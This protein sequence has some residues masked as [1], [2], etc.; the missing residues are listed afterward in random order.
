MAEL[1]AL[2]TPKKLANDDLIEKLEHLLGLAK[3]GKIDAFVGVAFRPNKNFIS[4]R[5][6]ITDAL[7]VVGLLEMLKHDVMTDMDA[8]ALPAELPSGDAG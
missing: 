3:E 7:V 8:N 6:R 2:P 1:R 4:V 5:S